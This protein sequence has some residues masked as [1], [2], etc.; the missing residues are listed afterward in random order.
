MINQLA[1]IPPK[2]S[3]SIFRTR[4]PLQRKKQL[5][6]EN[7]SLREAQTFDPRFVALSK[8]MQQIQEIIE[9]VAPSD[10]HVLI[11]GESG[12]GKGVIACL[13]H[14]RSLRAS[15]P[16]ITVNMGGLAEGV[17]ESEMFGHVKGAFTDARMDRVGRFELADNGTLFLDEIANL[18]AIQQAKLLR[19][20]ETGEFE[21]IGSSKTRHADV[22]LLSATNADLQED[23]NQGRFREDLFFRL[24]T[25]QIHLPPL[26]SRTEDIP[27]LAE[28]F[29]N[30]LSQQHRKW[31][32]GFHPETL[33]LL[34][35]Y[36][37]PGT[38][39]ELRHAIEHA[40]LLTRS[41]LIHPN[42]LS[43]QSRHPG[44]VPTLEEMNLEAAEAFLIQ[45]AL[46]RHHG[47]AALAA[48][49]LGV[50]RSAFYRRLQKHGIFNSLIIVWG[51][52]STCAMEM[53]SSE[54][55]LI[56]C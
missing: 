15:Q 13:L 26:R 33:S 11:T 5:E 4:I 46:E 49:T 35:S 16:L 7:S 40:I 56:L 50:S 45:R 36:P 51:Q 10:A 27:I 42:D 28:Q 54:L 20:L 3:T 41:D 30:E 6:A 29:L 24:N 1:L 22:R 43:L 19:V 32:T 38:V 25:I 47:N 12:T 48:K 2:P 18:T 17:F 44:K 34:K 14:Q 39:R 31:I 8:G 9:Q 55:C 53:L 23:I 21:R 37:W 52:I